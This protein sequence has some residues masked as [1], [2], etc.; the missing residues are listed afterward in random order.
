M[1]TEEEFMKGLK[2]AASLVFAISVLL[3]MANCNRNTNAGQTPAQPDIIAPDEENVNP[4][5]VFPIVKNPTQLEI[6]LAQNPK[7]LDYDTNEFT[8]FLEEKTGIDIQ[9]TMLPARD[10]A[11]KINLMFASDDLPEV[12]LGSLMLPDDMVLDYGTQGMILPLNKLIDK[13][14]DDI[15]RMFA[16]SVDKNMKNSIT[17]ADGNIYALP[18]ISELTSNLYGGITRMWVYKPWLDALNIKV[19]ENTEEFREMLRAFKTLDPNKNGRADEIPLIGFKSAIAM[20]I[21]TYLMSAFTY[22][23]GT[24]GF[25]VENEKIDAAYTKQEFRDGLTYLYE[26]CREGLLDPM[27]F[28]QDLQQMKTI[29]NQDIPI[30]GCWT[31][32]T[33]KSNLLDVTSQRSK[34]YV[35]IPPL[36]GPKGVQYAVIT[37]NIP[38]NA[39]VITKACK[40]P[41]AAYRLA[42]F[43]YSRESTLRGRYGIEGRDW[44]KPTSGE[45]SYLGKPAYMKLLTD[46]WGQPTHNVH[47]QN[48]NPGFLPGEIMDGQ[49]WNGDPYEYNYYS[50]RFIIDHYIGKEPAEYVPPRLSMSLAEMDEYNQLLATIMAYVNENVAQ[51][52]VGDKS[53]NN[54]DAY[55][56]EFQRMNLDRLISITQEA[57]NRAIK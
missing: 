1:F 7:I 45:L 41:A 18:K 53:L 28:T 22:F 19:P 20:D 17:F 9:F 34:E 25:I 31:N 6:A 50:T 52:I 33:A 16:E 44:A 10:T 27:S 26:L 3:I 39:F 47:W 35:L 37:P 49:V 30:I 46:V 2:K 32:N 11:S 43:M 21:A 23:D 38:V 29:I 42:D 8:A 40:S 48:P 55:L 14:G 56:A 13:Y 24:T 12:F 36:K 57:Y 15:N 5:G 4:K 51:F 54:W